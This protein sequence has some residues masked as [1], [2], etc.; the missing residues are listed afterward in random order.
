MNTF[1]I[2]SADGGGIRGIL[3]ARLI[4]RL[5]VLDADLYA[6][7][8]TGGI[9]ALGLAFG[10]KPEDLVDF[11]WKAG[12]TV[13]FRP[14]VFHRILGGVFNSQYDNTRL[15]DVLYSIF[16]E[17]KLGDLERKVL[18]PTFDLMAD[19]VG[20]WKPKFFHNLDSSDLD[21]RI[22]DVAL[23]TTAAP[24]YFPS[25]QG[26]IDGGIIANNPS[27][28]AL[29]Q[30]LD[31]GTVG[32]NLD[33]IRLLSISTGRL[34]QGIDGETLDWGLTKWIRYATNMAMEG[35][36]D[37][38]HYQCSRVLKNHYFRIDPVLPKRINLDDVSEVRDLI[39][40]ADEVELSNAEH[41]LDTNW[42]SNF[43]RSTEPD[44]EGTIPLV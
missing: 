6:G 14:T 15:Y 32:A 1:K 13:F 38:S 24:S 26:Y 10:L 3:L 30:S 23:R 5:G 39:Q 8:S 17:H 29:A 9:I 36:V 16:G 44:S 4:Q 11:Y 35:T 42:N 21:Q 33:D 12:Q 27:M 25:Y 7:T 20:T 43:G 18:I 19:D 31:R 2:L 40:I 37:V 22:V 41:W 28:C 34:S